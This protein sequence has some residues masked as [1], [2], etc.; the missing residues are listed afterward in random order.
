M[1]W[2]SIQTAPRDGTPIIIFNSMSAKW[3]KIVRRS[4]NVVSGGLEGPTWEIVFRDKIERFT[5]DYDEPAWVQAAKRSA[6]ASPDFGD[7]GS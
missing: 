3:S 2:Q 6:L 1:D 7:K 5:E 4:Q